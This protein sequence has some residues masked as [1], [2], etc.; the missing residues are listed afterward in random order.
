MLARLVHVLEQLVPREVLTLAHDRRESWVG[1]VD[2]VTLASLAPEFEADVPPGDPGVPIPQGRQ[3]E[4]AV[5]SGVLRVPHPDQ[6][7]L[8]QSR[9]RREDF[10]AREP[11][12]RQIAPNA[13]ADFRQPGGESEQSRVLGRVPRFPPARMVAI[14]LPPPSITADRLDVTVGRGADP[15]VRPRRR[16]CEGPDAT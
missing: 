7:G 16:N 9:D 6:R 10:L 3:A 1:D 2:D 5:L 15:D 8:Q 11:A 12:A 4:R 13:P 14:L